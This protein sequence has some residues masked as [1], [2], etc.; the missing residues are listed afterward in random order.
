[1][2]GRKG[3]RKNHSFFPVFKHHRILLCPRKK[4]SFMPE[5]PVWVGEKGEK[6]KKNTREKMSWHYFQQIEQ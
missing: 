4:L 2:Q 6:K 1:M 5:G 3:G